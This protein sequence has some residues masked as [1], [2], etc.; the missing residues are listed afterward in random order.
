[1][2]QL[3]ACAPYYMIGFKHLVCFN[4]PLMGLAYADWGVHTS[5]CMCIVLCVVALMLSQATGEQV[6]KAS[7]CEAQDVCYNAGM[8]VLAIRIPCRL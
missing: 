2:H 6:Y 8:S 4:K 5:C 1:M 3:M 7:V